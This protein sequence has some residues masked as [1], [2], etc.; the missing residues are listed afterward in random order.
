MEPL[1]Q[2]Q[3]IIN[4]GKKILKEFER[5]ERRD[6]ALRWMTNYLSQLIINAEGETNESKKKAIEKECCEVILKIWEKR[7]SLNHK[8]KPLANSEHLIDTI[9]ALK[10]QDGSLDWHRFDPYEQPGAWGEFVKEIRLNY[11]HVIM[12]SISAAESQELLKREKEWLDHKNLLTN[13][14]KQIIQQLD[15]LIVDNDKL[16][17]FVSARDQMKEEKKLS[18]KD[19]IIEMLDSVI[20]KQNKAL[21]KL[22]NAVKTG[23]L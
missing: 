4:L 15:G 22:K 17:R 8:A 14:E 11:N 18:R 3:E 16:I 10:E 1:K 21:E 7:D 13:E 12:L 19:Q 9:K 6:T 20:N 5:E 2:Y 23:T